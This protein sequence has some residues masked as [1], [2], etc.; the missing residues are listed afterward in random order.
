MTDADLDKLEARLR[1]LAN[2]HDWPNG[3]L[4]NVEMK[5]L[6]T[7]AADAVASARRDA[8]EIERLRGPLKPLAD[9]EIVEPDTPLPDDVSARYLFSMGEIRAARSALTAR[10]A[11]TGE[12]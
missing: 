6:A 4:H 1:S 3:S 9:C 2:A 11:H 10:A 5:A 12:G 8:E 7:E